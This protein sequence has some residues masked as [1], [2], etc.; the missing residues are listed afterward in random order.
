M[1]VMINYD[2]GVTSEWLMNAEGVKALSHFAM[3][4]K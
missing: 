3:S 2:V 4:E 1:G